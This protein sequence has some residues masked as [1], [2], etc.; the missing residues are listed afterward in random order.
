M[1]RL[2][3]DRGR[4]REQRAAQGTFALAPSPRQKA[5]ERQTFER[6]TGQDRGANERRRAR[7]DLDANAGL[8]RSCDEFAPRVGNAGRAGI[9]QE[10]HRAFP[11]AFQNGVGDFGGVLLAIAAYRFSGD[12][13]RAEQ[14]RRNAR[15]L[16]D[17]FVAGLQDVERAQRDIAQISD[18]RRD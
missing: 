6:K 3:P 14:A 18:R 8:A 1:R 17:D 7:Q 11:R 16:G 5:L 15:V 10:Q 2:V 12:A 4:A 13:V 9:A